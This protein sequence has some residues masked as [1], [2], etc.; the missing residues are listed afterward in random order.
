MSPDAAARVLARVVE[1][2]TIGVMFEVEWAYAA[3]DLIGPRPRVV[4]GNP[5]L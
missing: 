1:L 5:P 2:W 3:L 4:G